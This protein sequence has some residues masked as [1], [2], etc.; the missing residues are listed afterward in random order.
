MFYDIMI[1][2]FPWFY[3]QPLS[4]CRRHITVS[5]CNIC[6]DNHISHSFYSAIILVSLFYGLYR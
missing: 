6:H 2:W 4:E 3:A 1:L 5:L